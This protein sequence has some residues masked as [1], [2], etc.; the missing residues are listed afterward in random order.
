MS[1]YKDIQPFASPDQTRYVEPCEFE[2]ELLRPGAA[3]LKW[4]ACSA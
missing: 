3:H 1:K 2:E 4:H